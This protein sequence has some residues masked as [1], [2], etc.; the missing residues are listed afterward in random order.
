MSCNLRVAL[1]FAVWVC[2]FLMAVGLV[3][4]YIDLNPGNVDSYWP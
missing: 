4:C 3:F 2:R 1:N